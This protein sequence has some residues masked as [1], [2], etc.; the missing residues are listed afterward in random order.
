[1]SNLTSTEILHMNDVIEKCGCSC[2]NATSDEIHMVSCCEYT[3]QKTYREDCAICGNTLT[4]AK[5]VTWHYS[6]NHN[7][8]DMCSAEYKETDPRCSTGQYGEY[9]N[10]KLFEDPFYKEL[11]DR[12]NLTVIYFC[13]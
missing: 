13:G 9:E 10:F 7:A 11:I 8:C 2:H 1:M 4:D 5:N 6:T 12:L 3:Y